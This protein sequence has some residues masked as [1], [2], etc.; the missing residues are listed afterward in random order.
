MCVWS[1]R[2]W[3]W[4]AYA[5][6]S[7][8]EKTSVM[9]ELSPKWVQ[10]FRSDVPPSRGIWWSRAVLCKVSLTFTFMH[11]VGL[12]SGGQEQYYIRSAL[13]LHACIRS[14]WHVRMQMY[15][16]VEASGGQEQYYRRSAWHLQS[17]I[18]SEACN[19]QCSG[20]F[21]CTPTT[22]ILWPWM[23]LT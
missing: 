14:A 23:V 1:E 2:A 12:T 11:L 16:Q 21:K 6:W 7:F 5:Y 8:V 10:N 19:W 4:H 22:D 17:W 13:H 20:E 15:S 9:Q 18:T 3:Y